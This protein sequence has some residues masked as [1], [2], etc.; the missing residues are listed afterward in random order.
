MLVGIPGDV[1]TFFGGSNVS[2]HAQA[3]RRRQNRLEKPWSR[4]LR[5]PVGTKGIHEKE[6]HARIRN[7]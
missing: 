5:Q 6:I 4:Q 2:R 3:S 7:F 1:E